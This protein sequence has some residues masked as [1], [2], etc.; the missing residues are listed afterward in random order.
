MAELRTVTNYRLDL[1]NVELRLVLAALGGRL[2][3]ED[4]AE[5]DALGDRLTLQRVSNAK[6]LYEQN[7][8]LLRNVESKENDHWGTIS[9]RQKSPAAV[10]ERRLLPI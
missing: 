5:A 3:E 2:K 10:A 9:A 1:N 7:E 4:K 6:Q 8:R